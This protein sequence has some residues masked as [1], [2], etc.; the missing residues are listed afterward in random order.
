MRNFNYLKITLLFLVLCSC[1]P[2]EEK[3]KDNSQITVPKNGGI[4]KSN[5]GITSYI[6]DNFK[7][8]AEFEFVQ[9]FK[10]DTINSYQYQDLVNIVSYRI[11]VANNTNDLNLLGLKKF[12]LAFVE[13]YFEEYIRNLKKDETE[14][15]RIK[16]LNKDAIVY[17]YIV[18]NNSLIENK[19]A[20]LKSRILIVLNINKSYTL[21][22]VSEPEKLDQAFNDFIKRFSF[23]NDGNNEKYF[24][25]KYQYEIIFPSEYTLE[26]ASGKHID[27][28]L[29]KRDGISMLVNI[30]DRFPDE[31]RIS[32]H[33]YTKEY[34]ESS[35]KQTI[36]DIEIVKAEK[37]IIDNNKAFLIHYIVPS[38]DSKALEIYFFKGDF[39]YVL[40]ATSSIN[41]FSENETTFLNTFKSIKFK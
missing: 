37:L 36:P 12:D 11:N 40:T 14:F 17:D 15:K 24:S 16:F 33:D 30:S 35:F 22:I 19:K 41:K 2:K 31:Y 7:F 5:N 13:N 18:T 8:E 39:A 34:L 3:D 21:S 20:L 6:E 29:V 9:T 38:R 10:S 26:Q 27:L 4:E 1:L 28:K 32:A 25:S 23:I